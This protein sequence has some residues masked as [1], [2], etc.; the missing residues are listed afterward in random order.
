MQGFRP[1]IVKKKGEGYIAVPAYVGSLAE[2]RTV[3][4][5]KSVRAGEQEQNIQVSH[6]ISGTL[7]RSWLI[8]GHQPGLLNPDNSQAIQ[9]KERKGEGYIAVPAYK[10]YKDKAFNQE[11]RLLACSKK[12]INS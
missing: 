2:P 4:V 11:V 12:A 8:L 3:P 9:D 5:N 1:I 7:A 6:S 10:V